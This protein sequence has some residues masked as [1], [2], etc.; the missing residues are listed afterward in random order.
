MLSKHFVTPR[1]NFHI[2]W[3]L[4]FLH[5]AP[6]PDIALL[7]EIDSKRNHI[8]SLTTTVNDEITGTMPVSKAGLHSI[9]VA[10]CKLG[11]KP[12]FRFG[13]RQV[14]AGLRHVFGQLSTFLSKTWS[15]T[16]CIN[17]DMSRLM[18]Q[19]RWL[20][21]VLDKWNVEKSVS[22]QPKTCLSW[23]FVTYFI[24]RAYHDV[25]K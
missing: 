18:Q 4:N 22:S 9:I 24:I 3:T 16:C 1:I 21:R 6:N 10:S 5:F 14:R 17:L 20:V 25:I 23:I 19:V 2:N 13:F 12:G 11:R 15:R 8:R 7:E